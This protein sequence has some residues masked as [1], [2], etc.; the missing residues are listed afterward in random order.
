MQEY[1]NDPSDNESV[2]DQGDYDFTTWRKNARYFYNTALAH[3]LQWPSLTCQYLPIYDNREDTNIVYQKLI[4]GTQSTEEDNHLYISKVKL[5]NQRMKDEFSKKKFSIVQPKDGLVKEGSNCVEL[6][7]SILHP[8]EVVKARAKLNAYNIVGTKSSDGNVYIFDYSKQPTKP[9]DNIFK[10]LM[11]L[12]SENEGWGLDWKPN[13]HSIISSD[14][15]GH[16][17]I[18]DIEK[19][20]ILETMDNET[21]RFDPTTNFIYPL[22]DFQYKEAPITDIKYHKY[23]PSLFGS[24]SGTDLHI[25]DERQG[26]E[27]PFFDVTVHGKEV[28]S[29]DFSYHDEYLLLT[30]G[31][32]T[33]IKMWDMRNLNLPIY[34]FKHGEQSAV[35]VEWNPK[36]ESIFATCGEDKKV[37]VWDCTKITDSDHN[38]QNNCLAFHHCGH[39]GAVNDFSWN[40]Y[41]SLGIASV[42]AD[43]NLQIWEMNETFFE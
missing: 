2:I 9:K 32:D 20:K 21:N 39:T 16:I 41:V 40:P 30:T 11:V 18:W 15:K 42:D 23:H 35:K 38:I 17:Y 29:L 19:S 34:K 33:F 26:F 8:G 14:D 28:Y 27:K 22:N 1:N 10:P 6:E 5:P 7:T 24:V 25:W 13:G 3:V 36:E 12:P 37:N 43:N 31:E 4:L